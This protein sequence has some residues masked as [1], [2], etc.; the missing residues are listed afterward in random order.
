MSNP[1]SP[2]PTPIG[3]FQSHFGGPPGSSDL[4]AECKKWEKLCADLL[5]QRETLR[6]ELAE[7]QAECEMYRRSM[8]HNLCKDYKPDVDEA[9]G[10]AHMDDKPTVQE[11]IAELESAPGK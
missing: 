6:A 5:A 8:F 1:I 10:F 11:L 3:E 4:Q 2:G 7:K 9:I